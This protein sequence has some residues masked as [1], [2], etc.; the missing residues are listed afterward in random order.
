MQRTHRAFGKL[1]TVQRRRRETAQAIRNA[2]C[3]DGCHGFAGASKQT[4]G[5]KGRRSN[6]GGTSAAKKAGLGD[7]R[8]VHADGETENIATDRIAHFHR[9][10]G[11]KQLTSVARSAKVIENRGTKH[12]AKVTFL[13]M[14]A[15]LTL[16]RTLIADSGARP[17]CFNTA[18]YPSWP[19]RH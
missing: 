3:G 5:E 18:F 1:R 17:Y 16:Q 8:S 11:A 12:F 10:R 4:L 13:A 15:F 6:G 19:P 14:G 2:F 7:L 9:V